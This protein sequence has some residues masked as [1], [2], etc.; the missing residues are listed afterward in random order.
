MSTKWVSSFDLV[1]SQRLRRTYPS[2]HRIWDGIF[3]P[4]THHVIFFTCSKT[5]PN[6]LHYV[7]GACFTSWL[8]LIP[9]RKIEFLRS[10]ASCSSL[11]FSNVKVWKFI[12]WIEWD[13]CSCPMFT[14]LCSSRN[15]FRKYRLLLLF[16]KKIADWTRAAILETELK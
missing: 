13:H 10:T 12:E 4:N 9:K 3:F 6:I 2:F 7:I 8:C 5:M 11:C 15:G 16:E 14:S 1:L